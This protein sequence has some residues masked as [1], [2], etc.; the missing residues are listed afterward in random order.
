MSEVPDNKDH[1]VGNLGLT[2]HEEDQ[3]VAFLQTLTD[4]YTTPYPDINTFTGTCPTGGSAATQ[5]NEKLIPAP[6]PLPPC[7]NA[8]CGVAPTPGPS[9]IP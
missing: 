5:G 1:T 6:D 7:A 4:G 9:P 3:V 2:D 8:I